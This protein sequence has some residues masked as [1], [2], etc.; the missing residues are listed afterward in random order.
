MSTHNL[1][2]IFPINGL[3]YRF[4]K[5]SKAFAYYLNKRID[6]LSGIEENYSISLFNHS[7]ENKI[8]N[9]RV[10]PKVTHLF[11][12]YSFITESLENQ[13]NGDELLAI[14]IEYE[15][16]EIISW[17]ENS[18][19]VEF[20][21]IEEIGLPAYQEKFEAG[22]RE[23]LEGN[24]YQFNLTSP[25][26]YRFK[27]NK[28]EKD[29]YEILW[30]NGT[31][32]AAFAHFTY[33]GLWDKAYLSN[34]PECLFELNSEN[35]LVTKPIKGTLKR[36]SDDPEEIKVLWDKLQ[37]DQKNQAEL[38]MI[39]DL[40]RND[41]SRISI[42][43]A[44]VIA[45]KKMLLVPHL[46]HQYSEI[47][48]DL[49]DQTTLKQIVFALFPGGSITGAPKKNSI[50]IIKK[51]EKNL[52][53]FYCGSTILHFQENLKASINIRSAE[54]SLSSY[55]LKYSAGGGITL[56]SELK[57]EFSELIHKKVSFFSLFS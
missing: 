14:D 12:E 32:V 5:A 13:L 40:L 28:S 38:F 43:N 27:N 39:T 49:A 18:T 19:K 6:L 48:I 11:Y 55:I 9:K 24:C 20:D 54:I 7:L 16:S 15:N 21:L 50:R 36:E 51:L 42:P 25:S 45:A 46:I 33:I 44:K 29:F 4:D 8:S 22:Y 53:E 2:S 31:N 56:K 23:L 17:D 3:F 34:S 30:K 52:R 41:L 37:S 1:Y 35:T 47:S 57:D 26:F 10:L